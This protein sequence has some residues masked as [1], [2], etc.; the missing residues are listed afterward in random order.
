MASSVSSIEKL[1]T[2]SAGAALALVFARLCLLALAPG[3]LVSGALF[4]S[5]GGSGGAIGATTGA[6]VGVGAVRVCV[7]ALIPVSVRLG[8]LTLP[9]YSHS[10]IPSWFQEVHLLHAHPVLMSGASVCTCDIL[11]GHGWEASPM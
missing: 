3:L 6:G 10:L 2:A 4:V 11:F 8:L 5:F 9:Q 7:A 1:A